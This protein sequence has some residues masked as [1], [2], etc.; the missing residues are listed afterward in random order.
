MLGQADA[1]TGRSGSALMSLSG[2]GSTHDPIPSPMAMLRSPSGLRTIPS[3]SFPSPG[4][5]GHASP[6]FSPP[7]KTYTSAVAPLPRVAGAGWI[8][9]S[10]LVPFEV[11]TTRR[12]KPWK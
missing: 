8:A 3:N 9:Y 2:Q 4:P 10:K 1:V 11:V 5:F 6:A 7:G 12:L